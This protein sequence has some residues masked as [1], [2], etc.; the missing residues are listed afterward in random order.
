VN[1]AADAG[2]DQHH[3]HRK[4]VEPERDI[5]PQPADVNPSPEMVE[6]EAIGGR[7]RQHRGP[8]VH[9]DREGRGHRPAS[10]DAYRAL[11]ERALQDGARQKVYHRA[12]QGQQY[13]PAHET[14]R[15]RMLHRATASPQPHRNRADPTRGGIANGIASI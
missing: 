3:Q 12:E 11:A 15:E 7:P 13:D 6:H 2:N 1:Q 9:A 10:N 14:D 5:E 8:S 4:R